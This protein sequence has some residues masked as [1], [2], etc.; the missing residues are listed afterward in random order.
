MRCTICDATPVEEHHIRPRRI[1]TRLGIDIND[2]KEIVYLCRNCHGKVWI[3]GE[4]NGIHAVKGEEYIV[5]HGWK[6]EDPGCELVYDI[7]NEKKETRITYNLTKRKIEEKVKDVKT[8]KVIKIEERE[9][10]SSG[11][12]RKINYD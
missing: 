5:I 7:N 9:K 11:V 10:S 1:L 12:I 2:K 4:T 8:S 3:P 6:Y